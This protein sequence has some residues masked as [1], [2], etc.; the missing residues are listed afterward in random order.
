MAKRKEDL[1]LMD[2]EGTRLDIDYFVVTDTDFDEQIVRYGYLIDNHEYDL[3]LA[4]TLGLGVI[5][6]HDGDMSLLYNADG[7]RGKLREQS[8]MLRIATYYQITHPKYDDKELENLVMKTKGGKEYLKLLQTNDSDM[9]YEKLKSIFDSKKGIVIK[10]P[11][12][13]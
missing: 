11:T 8:E 7:N 2:L 5:E 9:P 4:V 1:H 6:S 10:F 13:N 3:D 12:N